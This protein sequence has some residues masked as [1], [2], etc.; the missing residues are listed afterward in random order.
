MADEKK[1]KANEQGP[2]TSE[3]RREARQDRL[4]RSL[5][6]LFPFE[7]R[8]DYGREMAH[9]FADQRREAELSGAP[10]LL[11][12]WWETL[13]GI[14][15]TAPR[16]HWEMF[17]SD[18]GFALRMMRK[19]PGFTAVVVLTLALG[20]GANTAIFSVINGVLLR[21]LPYAN[22]ARIVRLY[23]RAPLAGIQDAS[24]SPTEIRDFRERSHTL[25]D[26]VEY[27][28]MSFTFFGQGDPQRVVTGVV[29]ANFF[30]LLGVKPVLG[31][32]F[33]PGEDQ[34][35][36]EPVLL[37]TYGYWKNVMGGDP[38][39]IGKTFQMNDRVHTVVGVLPPL[40]SY[41]DTN[42]IYMPASS[43]PFRS[44][45]HT[46]TDRDARMLAAFARLKPGVTLAQAQADVAAVAANLAQEYPTHYPP[47]QGY[48][49]DAASL[50][51]ELTR[52]ARP[53][54]LVLLGASGLVLL[55]TCANVANLTLSRQIRR[56]HELAIRATLGASHARVF[57]Q[58]VT[59]STLLA[60]AGGALGLLVAGGSMSLLVAFAARFTPR[61]GDIR[62][63][64]MV[65][66]FAL[67]VSVFTGLLF[68]SIP[69]FGSRR[70]I[71]SALNQGVGRASDAAGRH[72]VRSVLITAQVAISFILLIGAGLMLRTLLKLQTVDTGFRSQNVLSSVIS[73][74]FTKY[75]EH[76]AQLAFYQKVLDALA[77]KPG[78]ISAAFASPFPLDTT[79][80]PFVGTMTI[81]G[82]PLPKGT[83]Y[84][85]ANV[86]VVSEQYFKTLGIPLVRGRF[87]TAADTQG[88]MDVILISQ[89][90]A[91]GHWPDSDPLGHRISLDDGKHWGTIVGVV[92]DV[93]Q[94]GLSRPPMDTLY[95]PLLQNA[96]LGGVLMVHTA[97]DPYQMA[98]TVVGAVHEVDPQQ[99][100]VRVR[101]LDDIH[102]EWLASPRLTATFI[103]LF[104]GLA[105]VITL[106]G[107]S[108]VTAL[109]VS[110]RTR[111]IGIR[112]ALG[113]T[114][115]SVLRMVVMQGMVLVVLGLVLGALSAPPLTRPMADLLFGVA[116]LDPLTY[117]AVAIVVLAVAATACFIPSRRAA[118]VDP[119]VALRSE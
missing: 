82:H 14:F 93:R 34:H 58:L 39:V 107:I 55:L 24:F 54:F 77:T 61:T 10:G 63:D 29:S 102:D 98:R 73:L 28:S 70:A 79:T 113:A 78:V 100:V 59:E 22:G 36:A 106:A 18:A 48:T 20:I 27:H 116:P 25:A 81:E 37:L 53:T 23:Q 71:A 109:A 45:E 57:R 83:P 103:A 75:S 114:R 3:K 43:C 76:S 94:Y 9:T 5:L 86:H 105:L 15:S 112:M 33:L 108:G 84:P 44:H 16:E 30:D 26:V 1:P 62:V 47:G 21:P 69:A 31:R 11:R 80:D 4:F 2:S 90:L 111:E 50:T 13:S 118:S 40:P 95:A 8:S 19:D 88:T 12:L 85:H 6:R 97:T 17:R 110:Q 96:Q 49:A 115:G 99:P 74:N 87:F 89:S 68:G 101:T 72:R 92:G 67:A 65:L 51:A 41:P 64:G 66:L 42:L 46:Q 52:A 7:F 56:E 117:I 38:N 91:R 119:L 60:V 104:A 32:L 35:G